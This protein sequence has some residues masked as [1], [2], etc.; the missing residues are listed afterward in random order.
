M[1]IPI[2]VA[3]I[4]L[5][6]NG[7]TRI[8]DRV[9]RLDPL[10]NY[11]EEMPGGAVKILRGA[12]A[13]AWWVKVPPLSVREDREAPTGLN[14]RMWQTILD[15]KS[16]AAD[17]KPLPAGFRQGWE[18]IIPT[19]TPDRVL[20]VEGREG[21]M[22]AD[23]ILGAI[24]RDEPGF[25]LV[26]APTLSPA[27]VEA[28]H[29]TAAR[30]LVE[31]EADGRL[32]EPGG[33]E[34]WGREV[35]DAT[36][37]PAASGRVLDAFAARLSLLNADR[38]RRVMAWETTSLGPIAAREWSATPSTVHLQEASD[39]PVYRVILPEG[40]EL[41]GDVVKL[42]QA[43]RTRYLDPSALVLAAAAGSL[44]LALAEGSADWRSRDP[45]LKPGGE[46]IRPPAPRVSIESMRAEV[47][48]TYERVAHAVVAAWAEDGYP[49]VVAAGL[50]EAPARPRPAEVLATLPGQRFFE[51]AS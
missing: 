35:L 30:I 17:R 45:R 42:G 5:V 13:P 46:A 26:D 23:C 19:W 33:A 44:G 20:R 51:W 11:R 37:T 7:E 27:E 29:G 28:K 6:R 12:K 39:S 25:R 31:H 4:W 50:P 24:R 41:L 36:T 15:P 34:R 2:Y 14:G 21:R 48:E 38:T 32:T 8:Y 47:R 9:A 1:N 16:K 10:A 40:A 49:N 22:T 3:E 18:L 43:E